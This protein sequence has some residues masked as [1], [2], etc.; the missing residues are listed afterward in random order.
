MEDVIQTIITRKKRK[1][2]SRATTK[3]EHQATK[4]CPRNTRRMSFFS[5]TPTP[6]VVDSP[7]P[8]Q[9]TGMEIQTVLEPGPELKASTSTTPDDSDE[10]LAHKQ[11][12][13]SEEK[14]EHD[15]RV[16]IV[17]AE[18]GHTTPARV[19]KSVSGGVSLDSTC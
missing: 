12:L 8:L 7:L 3:F 9:T 2:P 15:C 6:T 14:E 11:V 16:T 19:S 1:V 4:K 5:S 18:E 10:P 17:N 13:S